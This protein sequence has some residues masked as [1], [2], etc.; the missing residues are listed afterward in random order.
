M[1]RCGL[2]FSDFCTF[3]K[4]FS[5]HV[6]PFIQYHCRI[7]IKA[8]AVCRLPDASDVV[9]FWSANITIIAQW[10][11]VGKTLKQHYIFLTHNNLG[12]FTSDLFCFL[13]V[14]DTR[15]GH[16]MNVLSPL[17]LSSVIL[18]DSSTGSPVHVLMLSIQAV[19]GLPRLRE[20][21]IVP[22]IISFSRQLLCFL[23][24]WP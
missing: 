6:N 15:V 19:C 11:K 10:T 18:T 9:H 4:K 14:L 16:A 24:V 13:A 8:H 21:G 3:P 2:H 17:C 22:C 20:P 5:K 23:M 1:Q 7:N 12:Q